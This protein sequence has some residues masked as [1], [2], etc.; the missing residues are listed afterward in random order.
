V[1]PLN[2]W[3][4][5]AACLFTTGLYG[6]LTRR[7]AIALLLSVE[8]MANAVNL[9]LVAFG[10]WRGDLT[11]QVMAL[12]GIAL[13]VAEVAV[14]LAVIIQFNRTRKGISLDRATELGGGLSGEGAP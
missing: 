11:G 8:L 6:V 9:N 2:V 5:L 14:G 7:N 10:A 4:A 3:L 12:F 1:I 13:T